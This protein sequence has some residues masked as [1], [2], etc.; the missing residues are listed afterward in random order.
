[1]VASRA[2]GVRHV[3]LVTGTG[4]FTLRRA[5]RGRTR[6]TWDEQLRFPLWLG[7]PVGGVVGAP[8]MRMIWRRSLRNLKAHRRVGRQARMSGWGTWSGSRRSSP[9]CR[10]PSGSTSRRGAASRRSAS[11]ARTSSSPTRRRRGISVKLPKEEAAAVV[12]TDP[13]R[14][15]ARLRARPARLGLGHDPGAKPSA[16]AVAAGR[17]VG[18]HVVH[19]GRAEAAGHASCSRRTREPTISLG[20]MRDGQDAVARPRP[21]RA[22]SVTTTS[23]PST[24]CS[25]SSRTHGTRPRLPSSTS[26]AP[27]WQPTRHKV[28]EAVGRERRQCVTNRQER[29]R[30]PRGIACA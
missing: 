26:S 6:F 25:V 14:R 8:L 21:R 27:R 17:G 28:A 23:A 5:R 7:G 11:T 24:C 30:S 9:G 18:A 4:R 19:D 16:D 12:A 1:M 3:G 10:R 2:M 29:S 20:S 13:A 15:A 22:T